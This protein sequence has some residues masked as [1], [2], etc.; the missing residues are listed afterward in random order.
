MAKSKN[1]LTAL[2]ILFTV[3]CNYGQ[4]NLRKAVIDTALSQVGVREATGNNDGKSVEKYLKACNLGKGYAWCAAFI[5]WNYTVNGVKA[6]KSAWAPSWFS[7]KNTIWKR[8]SLNNENPRSG[9]VFGLWINNRIGHVGFVYKWGD[10]VTTTIEGNTNE[11]GSREGDGV[12][13]KKRLTRQIYI[14][15]KWV[16]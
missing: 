15:S 13:M 16:D 14:V 7:P 1:I 2:L 8:N 11:A 9:D 6:I 3:V 4:S 12:Y 10:K 5:T